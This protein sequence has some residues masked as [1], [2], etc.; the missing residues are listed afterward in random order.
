MAVSLW[1]SFTLTLSYF[2]EGGGGLGG[3]FLGV[4]HCTA[5]SWVG[6]LCSAVAGS[7]SRVQMVSIILAGNFQTDQEDRRGSLTV[8]GCI[9]RLHP[10][11]GGILWDY[12]VVYLQLQIFLILFY[13]HLAIISSWRWL[14][15]FCSRLLLVMV[16][17]SATSDYRL[18]PLGLQITAALWCWLQPLL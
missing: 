8:Y 16:R 3:R 9:Y 4:P 15:I 18:L 2:V 5:V 7:A 12:F 14:Q 6:Q 13:F 1:L 11:S 10:K 17:I